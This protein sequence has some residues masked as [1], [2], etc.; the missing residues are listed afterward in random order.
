MKKKME[1]VEQVGDIFVLKSTLD[2]LKLLSEG[3]K[4]EILE[5]KEE[6]QQ[7]RKSSEMG[8]SVRIIKKYE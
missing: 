1:E 6:N 3:Q 2:E 4:K 8:E 7:A 5:L